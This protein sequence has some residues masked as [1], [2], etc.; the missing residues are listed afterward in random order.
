MNLNGLAFYVTQLTQPTEKRR[1]QFVSLL[2][3]AKQ[4]HSDPPDSTLLRTRCERPRSRTTPERRENCVASFRHQVREAA[5]YRFDLVFD[6]GR[7]RLRAKPSGCSRCRSWVKIGK[8]QIENNNT[9][10][11]L[12]VFDLEI[13]W[14]CNANTSKGL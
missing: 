3:P 1:P 5:T 9:A 14:A 8:S 7:D 6:R 2:P 11:D 10:S 4:K 12:L 13:E